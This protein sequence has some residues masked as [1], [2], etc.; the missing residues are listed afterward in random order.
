MTRKALGRGLGALLSEPPKSNSSEDFIE[1]DLDLIEP[2]VMQ[3]RRRFDEQKLEELAQSIRSNG[4]VQPL[5]VRRVGNRYQLIA[6]ERRWRASQLAGIQKVPAV[7]KDI[8]DDKLLELALIENI[9]RQELNP[10]E[11]A[12]AYK[13]LI[14]SLNLTQEEVAQRVGRDRTFV[15]NYL[16]ILKL[17]SEI[18][19]LLENEKLSF[20]HARALL[21]LG[22]VILQRRYAQKIVKHNL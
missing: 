10:I 15:T 7:V 3:P 11:E 2:N 18:Q 22:D 6:G 9:Q 16:R 20:G 19:L 8:P 13:R 14:E 1:I 12:N 4:V 5:L 21:G 17:P